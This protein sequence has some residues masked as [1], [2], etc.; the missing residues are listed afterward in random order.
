MKVILASLPDF[1]LNASQAGCLS[2]LMSRRAYASTYI[3]ADSR[4]SVAM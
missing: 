4:L 1:N 3:H 2:S